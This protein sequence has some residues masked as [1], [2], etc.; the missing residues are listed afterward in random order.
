MTSS[1][2][3][4]LPT[5][6]SLFPR[7][8]LTGI[9]GSGKSTI[10]RILADYLDWKFIDTDHLIEDK[11]GKSVAAIFDEDGEDYFRKLEHEMV[12][13]ICSLSNLVV[14]SGG[15]MFM[16]AENR[17]ALTEESL[18]VHL[19]VSVSSIMDRVNSFDDRPL[20]RG[21]PEEN[22]RRIYHSRRSVYETI[23]LQIETDGRDPAHIAQE[24][25]SHLIT[26]HRVLHSGSY[27]VHSG[28][29][30]SST[31]ARL[32]TEEKI[33]SPVVLLTDETVWRIAGNWWLGRI[34]SETEGRFRFEVITLPGAES[35]KSTG[36]LVDLWER[37][38]ELRIRRDGCIIVVGGGVL[39]DLGGFVASTLLRGLPLIQIPTTLLA[40]VDA[41]IGGK[42]GINIKSTKNMVGTFYPANHTLLDP[43][44]LYSLSDREFSC[45]LAEMIKAALLGDADFFVFLEE[46]MN[47]IISRKLALL[48]ESVERSA[49]IKLDIVGQDLHDRTGKRALLNLGHT[50]AHALESFSKFDLRHGEAVSIGLVLATRFSIMK[51]QCSGDVLPRLISL[52]KAAG[53]PV[54]VPTGNTE[55]LIEKMMFD[56][57]HEKNKL[58]L[59]IPNKIGQAALYPVTEHNDLLLAFE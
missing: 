56:K 55:K 25:L 41:S 2:S 48:I 4:P 31:L 46:N 57:K 7:I 38:I 39:G 21:N 54:E 29:N 22:L 12:T 52:L 34:Q 32:L 3:S 35:S 30:L 9:M 24:I 26:F 37:L 23:P 14:A 40:Q 20:L 17:K 58:N 10:G 16:D 43:I 51:G 5:Q 8:V 27:T 13:E 36:M 47:E 49:K 6:A 28:F 44:F 59:V 42:T 18:A 53:L 33:T 1:K 50:F 15:G 11:C 45:G 19:C